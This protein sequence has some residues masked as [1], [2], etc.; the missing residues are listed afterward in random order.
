M[1]K[2]SW[3]ALLLVGIL[4]PP[5]PGP[6]LRGFD[7]T[8]PYGP[9]QRGLQYATQPFEAV[10]APHAGT[11]SFVGTV[12]GRSVLTIRWVEHGAGPDTTYQLTLSPISGTVPAMGTPVNA[13]DPVGNAIGNTLLLTLRRDGTY[14]DPTPLFAQRLRTYLIPMEEF[15]AYPL[16]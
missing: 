10:H 5:V 12:A 3:R 13:H 8:T 14:L 15:Q 4:V 16:Q 6:V 11:I 2:H 9:G 7:A 1:R